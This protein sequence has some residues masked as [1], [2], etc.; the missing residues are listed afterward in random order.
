MPGRYKA[1]PEYKDSG[2]EWLGKVSAQWLFSKHKYIARFQKGKNPTHLLDEQIDGTI[3]YLSMDFLRGNSKSSYAKIE[4]S[5]Y[6]SKENQILLIWDGSNAGEFVKGKFG[7]VSS[8]MA[9]SELISEISEKFYWY[10]CVC[11]EPEMRKNAT[12]MGIP[13]VN[14]EELKNAAIPLPSI[15]E[16]NQISNFLDHETG[17]IDALIEKQ[18]QLIK[19][20]QE[21]R[22]AVI[23]HA[24]TKG[25]NPAAPM[26][27]S[28]VEW[29]GQVPAHWSVVALKRLV[30]IPIIDGPH[31]SPEKFDEGVPFVSAEAIKNGQID[32]DKIWGY[33]SEEESARFSKRY[34][35]KKDDILVV[36]LGATTGAAAIVSTEAKFNI[37]VPLAAMRLKQQVSPQFVFYTMKSAQIRDAIQISWTYGTQQTL[38]LKTL[39]N[40]QIVVPTEKEQKII[41]EFLEKRV[42]VL[43]ALEYKA[44]EQIN[45]LQERRTA[46][47]SAAVTGK[48][49]VRAW[50]APAGSTVYSVQKA[51]NS[52]YE[53]EME[54]PGNGEEVADD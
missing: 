52:G 25:L 48:I 34:A 20:L 29:L 31:E 28:G 21:K 26:K 23:S 11:L 53:N 36:K 30:S 32:F 7:I 17:K 46:L 10:V 42:P 40:L 45:F 22:Q 14:G 19:L 4:K 9:A 43:D 24:V 51:Q 18:Q 27:D 15:F 13:H 1:Y 39:G 12:G 41:V 37:W 50:R 5:A 3:S 47:I 44:N 35:P 8:T 6:V 33:I 49:D 2:V 16:Q 54:M 38:G